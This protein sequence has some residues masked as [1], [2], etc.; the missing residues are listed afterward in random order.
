MSSHRSAL[1][2]ESFR[3][4]RRL[5]DGDELALRSIRVRAQP[6]IVKSETPNWQVS[7]K[8]AGWTAVRK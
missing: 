8:S 3:D 7:Q 6:Q 2:F 4:A 5:R 1:L